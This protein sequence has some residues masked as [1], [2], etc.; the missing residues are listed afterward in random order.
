MSAASVSRH[1]ACDLGAESGRVM[2]GTL[3]GEGAAARLDL[4]ELHRFPTGAMAVN[5]SLRWDFLH[6]WAGICEGLRRAAARGEPIAS[7]SSDSWGVDYV[8]G[9]GEEPMLTAPYHYRDAR[10]DG[11]YERVFAKI[12]QAAVFEATGI[13]FMLINT[14]FQMEAETRVRPEIL[15][16]A[17]RFLGIGDQVNWLLSG[18]ARSEASLASTTQMYDPRARAW[19][20]AIIAALGLPARIFPAIVPS[21][22]VLGPLRAGVAAA[23]GLAGAQVVATCSHDTGAAVA[24][25]PAGGG[26]EWAYLSSGTWSL[27]GIESPAPIITEASRAAN[28]TNEAGYGGTT[29][30]LKNIS[31][32][33]I[34]QECRRVWLAAGG[35]ADELS[36]EKLAALAA[37]AAPVAA[38]INP[39]D[40]RF[41][42]VADMPARIAGYCRETGQAAPVGPGATVRCI[43]ESLALSYR[44]TLDEIAAVTGRRPNKLH[45]VGGGTKNILLNQLAADATGLP[46]VAGP[47]EATAA[48]NILIQAI[49]L[50]RVA[51]IADARAVVGASFPLTT[52]QPR[53]PAAWQA[54]YRRFQELP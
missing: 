7:V 49:A 40:P 31:G 30:F 16:V 54:A 48:G 41:G 46:V 19:S 10:T 29:R 33:W 18:V 14:L 37:Q 23:T 42:Q 17:E 44:R 34:L 50:G 39:A 52:Y 27:L 6:I 1:L 43:L 3:V 26:G 45:I 8:L 4:E 15:A 2:L 36:Y 25:V 9:R 22:T 13:Q 21:G 28:F 20:P 5:G 11:G 12:P 51:S 53:D 24:A 38:L 47:V 35:A 32:L